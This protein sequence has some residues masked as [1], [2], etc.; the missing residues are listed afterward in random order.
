ME[1]RFPSVLNSGLLIE[2]GGIPMA[3]FNNRLSLVRGTSP[4]RSTG[5]TTRTHQGGVGHL[6]DAK[7]ELFLLAV[8]NFV[9]QQTFYESGDDRDDRFASLVHKLAV[10]E[11][12]W[13]AALLS[14]L[15]RD[16]N[17]RTAAIVGAA[18]YVKARLELGQGP[19]DQ[20][21]CP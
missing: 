10:E 15:R 18:E 3:R 13:T 4:V 20:R 8:A 21:N 5:S 16:G 7:S 12:S 19:P 11:P 2:F 14:W 9:S 1:T 17:M 6:R